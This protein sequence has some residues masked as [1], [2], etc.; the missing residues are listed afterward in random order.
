MRRFEYCTTHTKHPTNGVRYR[1]LQT[2]YPLPMP[3]DYNTLLPKVNTLLQY[4]T[5]LRANTPHPPPKKKNMS[6]HTRRSSPV[7]CKHTASTGGVHSAKSDWMMPKAVGLLATSSDRSGR[8]PPPGPPARADWSTPPVDSA[9]TNM[10]T[11]TRAVSLDVSLDGRDLG[12]P[13][14][15]PKAKRTHS[16]VI[17]THYDITSYITRCLGVRHELGTASASQALKKQ[18]GG[19]RQR[20][21]SSCLLNRVPPSSA[22]S[23]VQAL[24][25]GGLSSSSAP[26]TRPSRNR[27]QTRNPGRTRGRNGW[28]TAPC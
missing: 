2:R 28:R 14:V 9:D 11:C 23:P 3:L 19:R 24:P 10:H 16:R 17:E 1:I 7:T 18:S 12:R 8:I 27:R 13:Q 4:H 22:T 20:F 15:L 25:V 26:C 21:K 5:Q 6:K